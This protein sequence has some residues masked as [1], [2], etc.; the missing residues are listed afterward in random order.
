MV[1]VCFVVESNLASIH[2]VINY[3]EHEHGGICR[4]AHTHSLQRQ[5]QWAGN[6]PI[7][8]LRHHPGRQ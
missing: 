7:S 1:Y 5:G 2:I 8:R 4:R 6:N 3:E